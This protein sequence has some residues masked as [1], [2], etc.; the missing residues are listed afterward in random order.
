MKQRDV[1]LRSEGDAWLERNLPGSPLA[2]PESDEVLLAILQLPLSQ[3]AGPAKV[4]EIGCG[5]ASRL[6]WLRENRGFD[7]YGIDPSANAVK[8]AKARGIVAH[9]GTAEMLGF[10]A[11]A[12]DIVVFGFCLYLCDRE[13]LFRIAAEADRVLR[14]PGWMVIHDFYSPTPSQRPYRHQSG[15]FSFKM[16]YR[17]LFA[18]HPGYRNYFHKLS[19]HID[20]T[21]TDDRDEWVATSVLRKLL[22]QCD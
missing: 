20:G 2:L 15:I 5:S 9:Q 6:E 3:T 16:D 10:D 14:N 4:L 18:W 7:C 8:E 11:A 13:D 17:T 12:F 22:I 21:Y 19:H 1:F